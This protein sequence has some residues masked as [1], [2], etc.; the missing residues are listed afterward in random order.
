M[1]PLIPTQ[2][3]SLRHLLAVLLFTST[4]T[5]AYLSC[6]WAAE[7]GSAAAANSYQHLRHARGVIKGGP[8]ARNVAAGKAEVG[9]ANLDLNLERRQPSAPQEDES[10]R[11][12][13]PAPSPAHVIRDCLAQITPA[14]SLQKRQDQGQINALSGEIQR[15]S[16]SFRSVSQASQQ[17]SQ[18][19]QQLSQSLQQANQRLIQTE[20][21]IASLRAQKDI[22]EQASRSATQAAND[23]SRRADEAS[24]SASRA[25]SAAFSEASRSASEMMAQVTRDMAASASSAIAAASQSVVF[26]ANSAA[27]RIQQAQAEATA[28]RNDAQ[29]QVQ[30]AQGAAL[31]VTQAALA[32]VGGIVGSSLITVVVVVL[33]MRY[34]RK[35]QQREALR[36]GGGSS[37]RGFGG[38]GRG[39]FGGGEENVTAVRGPAMGIGDYKMADYENESN[40]SSS[41]PPPSSR[42]SAVGYPPDKKEPVAPPAAAVLNRSNSSGERKPGVGTGGGPGGFKLRDP[43]APKSN[44]FT[45]FPSP[46]SSA[47]PKGSSGSPNARGSKSMFP[48]LDTWLRN[49]TTVSPFATVNK[50]AAD[51]LG[52]GIATTTEGRKSPEWPI[53]RT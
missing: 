46:S 48:T 28:V 23:A 10:I 40:Y 37:S 32:V 6:A 16:E 53:R 20:A 43:P 26:V 47:S 41:S 7:D 36:M 33:V 12:R 25:I 13:N 19:S 2:L 24:A 8:G 42:Y 45:L 51:A 30:Q 21:S 17:V 22:A 11:G 39:S 18:S 3:F 34:R 27:S 50:G 29:S 15:L 52:V 4:F 38:M 1:R 9:G 14:P 31:S 49:G 35:K 44:K 5:P